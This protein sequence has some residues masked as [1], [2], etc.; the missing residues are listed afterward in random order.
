[1]KKKPAQTTH[2]NEWAI[3]T[4]DHHERVLLQQQE[5]GKRREGMWSLPRRP[6]QEIT[7]LPLI[8]KTTYSITR[9]RVTLHIHSAETIH[10]KPQE[11]SLTEL[12]FEPNNL[13]DLPMPSPD[14][15]AL[16]NLLPPATVDDRI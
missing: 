5:T 16:E 6:Q 1:V 8:H 11:N 2:V 3:F 9:Y 13:K 15:R 4:R 14:R 7:N 12:W 10:L